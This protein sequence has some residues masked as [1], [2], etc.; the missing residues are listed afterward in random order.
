MLVSGCDLGSR[1]RVGFSARGVHISSWSVVSVV[2]EV[3]GESS[4][5][6]DS[7]NR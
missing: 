3:V 2:I 6:V 4:L 7:E 5:L 1:S